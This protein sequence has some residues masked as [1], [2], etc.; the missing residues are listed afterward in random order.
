MNTVTEDLKKI[1]NTFD[2]PLELFR[3]TIPR[4]PY[5]TDV[6]GNLYIRPAVEAIKRRYIQPN[7]PFDLQWFVFDVDRPTAHF[8]WQ[9]RNAPAPN[10]TAMNPENGHSHLFY[11]L[12]VPV[13]KCEM[14]PKVHKKPIRYAARAENALSTVLDAD[15]NYAGLIC[16]NP[17]HDYWD[18]KVWEKYSY[19]L[20]GLL[21]YFCF[22]KYK[23]RRRRLPSVGLG[24][25]CTL[26][27]LT[28]H[29]A[30]R[31]IRKE[32]GY[33]SEDLFIFECINYAGYKNQEF[34]N[35]LP[36]SEVRATGKSIGRWTYRN[37]SADGFIDWC[38]RRGKA[39]NKKSIVVRKTKA[40]ER[41]EGI[42]EYKM[43]HPEATNKD[44]STLFQVS[45][46][47]VAGLKLSGL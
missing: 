29:W 23:D 36:Y 18:V 43:A 17:L 19:S 33:L 13:I 9:D 34:D 14:N 25:N 22:D 8:D 24:R 5:C 20:D 6:L 15:P 4:K 47:T 37:M 32:Q 41:T 28:R 40:Q 44:I 27:D 10:I 12:E 30:Y 31:E 11:G 45:L 39:G 38:K 21:D 7:S 35:P 26:F 16:K 46:R 2:A 3:E 1:N 42:R